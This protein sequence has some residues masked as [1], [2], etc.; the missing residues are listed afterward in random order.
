M[1]QWLSEVRYKQEMGTNTAM[2][3]ILQMDLPST[4]FSN[5]E[6][7]TGVNRQLLEELIKSREE[8]AEQGLAEA[9]ARTVPFLK[10][11]FPLPVVPQLTGR[12]YEQM[13]SL[14]INNFDRANDKLTE[15]LS[16]NVCSAFVR[17]CELQPRCHG[18]NL[19]SFLIQPVQRVPRYKLLIA[20]ML[21]HTEERHADF[22]KLQQA[23]QSISKVAANINEGVAQQ[24]QRMKVRELASCSILDLISAQP[25]AGYRDAGCL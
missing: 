23:L 9:I 13:Y 7:M 14:Y 12:T 20:E 3:D 1:K 15:A 6:Q 11:G 22:Q 25:P 16:N 10:V 19:R 17:A 8:G 2:Q 24:E 4:V 5:I 18:L 21:K